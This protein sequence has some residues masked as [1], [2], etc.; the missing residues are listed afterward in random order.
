MQEREV[1]LRSQCDRCFKEHRATTAKPAHRVALSE[2]PLPDGWSKAVSR[3]GVPLDFCS[4][5]CAAQERAH[6]TVS[7]PDGAACLVWQNHIGHPGWHP[8][9]S[10]GDGRGIY[11]RNGLLATG[12]SID[13]APGHPLR[14]VF[15]FCVPS[16]AEL[17]AWKA[18]T[19]PPPYQHSFLDSGYLDR[20]DMTVRD[21][22]CL[23]RQSVSQGTRKALSLLRVL[24]ELEEAGRI[25]WLDYNPYG[26]T[27][28]AR[29]VRTI[30]ESPTPPA[31]GRHAGTL[32]E[33]ATQLA[34]R[35]D[36]EVREQRPGQPQ[37]E[38]LVH[39]FPYAGRELRSAATTFRQLSKLAPPPLR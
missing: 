9:L 23:A 1:T 3:E 7:L 27:V 37:R 24:R 22:L 5:D 17:A 13:P 21:F 18:W 6:P 25:D 11:R 20:F 36:H 12:P 35:L 29:E 8:A 38:V 33:W 26:T 31:L 30:A 4:A 10:V 14:E 28:F 39:T 2:A 16:A 34:D 15:P 32:A 19:K